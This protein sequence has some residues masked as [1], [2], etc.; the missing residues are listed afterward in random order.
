MFSLFQRSVSDTLIR[1]LTTDDWGQLDAMIAQDPVAFLYA[2]EHLDHFGL[3]APSALASRSG[4]GFMGIFVP[5][6]KSRPV[7]NPGLEPAPAPAR[8]LDLVYTLGAASSSIA[9]RL[10]ATARR[11]AQKFLSPLSQINEGDQSPA[12]ATE[13]APPGGQLKLVGAFWLGSNLVPLVVPEQFRAAVAASITRSHRSLASIFGYADDVLPLWELIA[14][15]LPLPLSVRENQPLMVLP[16]SAD[17]EA[18]GR[19]SLY[20]EGLQAPQLSEDGARWARTSDRRSLLKASVAMFT[21]EVGYDPLSRDPAGYTRRV[22]EFVR[23]GRTVVA[24]NTEGVVVFKADLGLAFGEHCQIQ[25]VWL[26]PA[27]RG[28]GLST[29]LLAQAFELI[30][31]RFPQISLYV[32]DFNTR[33][34][35]LYES[36]GMEQIGTFATV[37]F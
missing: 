28:R 32:N 10:P 17:L 36:I 20:R 22:D 8:N 23:T 29:P 2:A 14:G 5:A 31:P 15:K 4:H 3:P 1:P 18:V 21:E 26:H 7:A 24:T 25:G 11:A 37:V 19:A 6:E 33:A 12:P 35:K 13:P 9:E 30:K 34:R 27:Y 16:D